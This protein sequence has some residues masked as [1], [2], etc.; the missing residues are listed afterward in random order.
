MPSNILLREPYH[1]ATVLGV[2]FPMLASSILLQ[3]TKCQSGRYRHILSTIHNEIRNDSLV[4]ASSRPAPFQ[5]L[6]IYGR[7]PASNTKSRYPSLSPMMFPIAQAD[8][9]KN[10]KP[11]F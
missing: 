8:Y 5:I 1:L 6:S 7:N 9:F 4:L 3:L 10:P 11:V 2:K